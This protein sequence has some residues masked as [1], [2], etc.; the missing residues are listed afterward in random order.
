MGPVANDIM[1]PSMG[2]NPLI[3][4]LLDDPAVVEQYRAIV[5]ELSKT[6]FAR[7]ELE[8]ILVDLEKINPRRDPALRTFIDSRTAYVQTLVAGWEK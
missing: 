4:W 6:V 5:K 8:K 1:R 2:D 3:Y 7:A